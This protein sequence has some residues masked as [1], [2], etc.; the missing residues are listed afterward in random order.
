MRLLEAFMLFEIRR[1]FRCAIVPRFGQNVPVLS[2]L[3]SPCRIW[4]ESAEAP[5]LPGSSINFKFYD[6]DC[7]N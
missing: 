1:D 7:M 3:F 4:I 5:P 2:H 6:F